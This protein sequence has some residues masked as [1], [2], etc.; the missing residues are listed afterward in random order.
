[1]RT[2]DLWRI[3]SACL[4]KQSPGDDAWVT[5]TAAADV[6]RIALT[7][8]VSF[9]AIAK[10]VEGA[11]CPWP[12]AAQ[13]IAI[14]QGMLDHTRQSPGEHEVWRVRYFTARLL[15]STGDLDSAVGLA[16]QAWADSAWN[17]GVGILVFQLHAS[18]EDVAACRR[19][20]EQLKATVGAGD[21]RGQEAIAS[22]ESHVIDAES[23]AGAAQAAQ[24]P[25][26]KAGAPTTLQPPSPSAR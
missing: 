21:L 5:A 13:A 7:E 14:G 16:E 8:M 22:F 19:T 24:E 12:S 9:E 20:L 4:A 1:V 26:A 6:P 2:L 3:L 11:D 23:R 10:R 15:A 17:A 25:R 18:R